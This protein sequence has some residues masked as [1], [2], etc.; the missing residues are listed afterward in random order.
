MLTPLLISFIL[1]FCLVLAISFVAYKVTANLSDYILGGRRLGGAVAALSAGASDMSAWL[2]LG[3]PGAV[4][5]FG[6]NQCWLPIGLIIG[7]YLNWLFIAKPL[8]VYTE[9]VND[10][11]TIPEFLA[12]RFGPNYASVMRLVSSAAL[13]IFFAF[14]SASG[15]VGGALLLQKTFPSLDYMQAL[16]LGSTIIV[17][18]TFVGGFLAVSWT[19]FFQGTFMFL[20][21]LIV[22]FMATQNLHGI[23]ETVKTLNLQDIHLLDPLHGVS[24]LLVVNLMAWGLGYFGQPHILVRFMAVSSTKEIPTARRIGMGWMAFSLIGAMLTGLV[25]RAYFTEGLVNPESVFIHF[26]SELFTPALSG[27]ILA[28]ILSSIMCALDSQLLASA[29]AL[30]ED[31]YHPFIRKNATQR[32]LVWVGRVAVVCI[33][34]I[35]LA[36]ASDPNSK[37]LTLVGFAWAG[38]GATFGPVIILSLF[39]KR[40]TGTGAVMGMV[41]GASTVI[42]WKLLDSPVLY[43]II[44]GF[45][46]AALLAWLVSLAGK[47]PA[48]AIVHRHEEIMAKLRTL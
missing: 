7:A 14:Y 25:G 37:V 29:S 40:L 35:A 48:P 36:L 34:L 20:C 31:L 11:L 43:E 32:E 27:I 18:Y 26:S 9:V 13:L 24:L 17:G 2:L 39:W 30:T 45:I 38:L 23:D 41:G 4:Y 3:L 15:L 5:T 44:P 1:Y 19:D 6:L 12:N 22:P 33:A 46:V 42:V 21:L 28:A 47:R 16:L 8:R 10:S